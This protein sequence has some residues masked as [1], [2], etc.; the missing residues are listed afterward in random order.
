[1]NSLQTQL[2]VLEMGSIT[3]MIKETIKRPEIKYM[4]KNKERAQKPEIGTV[5]NK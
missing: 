4:P 1:M 5:K 2:F 3:P